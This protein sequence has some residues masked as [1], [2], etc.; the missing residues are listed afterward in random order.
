[1]PLPNEA[2]STHFFSTNSWYQTRLTRVLQRLY[3]YAGSSALRSP[4]LSLP[5]KKTQYSTY[6]ALGAVSYQLCSKQCQHILE[7]PSMW[8]NFRP[9]TIL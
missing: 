4:S 8:S 1:M 5:K 3:I 2:I 9:F 6:Y 7:R